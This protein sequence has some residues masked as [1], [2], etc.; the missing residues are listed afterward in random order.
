M[1]DDFVSWT[2]FSSWRFADHTATAGGLNRL[3]LNA[4]LTT[5]TEDSPM[6][7]AAKIGLRRIPKKGKSTLVNKPGNSRPRS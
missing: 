1:I 5:V 4:L 7:A 3:S 6:A 2:L